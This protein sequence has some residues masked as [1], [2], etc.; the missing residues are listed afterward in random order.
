GLARELTTSTAFMTPTERYVTMLQY[1][2]QSVT[3]SVVGSVKKLRVLSKCLYLAP[4]EWSKGIF[5]FQPTHFFTY[6]QYS[7][8]EYYYTPCLAHHHRHAPAVA[9]RETG[10]GRTP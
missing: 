1:Y 7:Q 6:A 10:P 5:T 9:W 8:D 3:K 4:L 2:S